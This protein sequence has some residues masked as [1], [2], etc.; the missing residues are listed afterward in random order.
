MFR[1]VPPP[2]VDIPNPN[3]ATPPPMGLTNLP[4][5]PPTPAVPQMP[6]MPQMPAGV[7][8]QA[9]PGLGAPGVP[10]MSAMP[11]MPPMP[12]EQM[13]LKA[14]GQTTNLLGFPCTRYELKQRGEEMEIWATDKLFP[15]QPYLQN[16]PHRFGARMIEERWGEMMKA[17]KLF[18]LLAVLRLDTSAIPT[19]A[20]QV[21]VPERMRFEV[22]SVVAEKIGKEDTEKLFQPPPDYQEIQPMPF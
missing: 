10:G 14:T 19:N 22:K 15:F 3:A 8:P 11:M 20:P 17:K 16:Q 9:G 7:G 18:P 2:P 12:M 4:G 13:Q 6:A 21:S 1:S 5:M